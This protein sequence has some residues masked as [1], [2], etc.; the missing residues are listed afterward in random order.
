MSTPPSS[1]TMAVVP[2]SKRW[3]IGTKINGDGRAGGDP[4][5][6]GLIE[7]QVGDKLNGQCKLYADAPSCAKLF[8]VAF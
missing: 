2:Y 7:C 4:D 6:E 1:K 3:P 5:S 8:C